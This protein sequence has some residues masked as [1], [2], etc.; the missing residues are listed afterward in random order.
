MNELKTKSGR[1]FYLTIVISVL[2]LFG[3]LVT[4][5]HAE[6]TKNFEEFCETLVT[7]LF[8]Y[9]GGNVGNKWLGGKTEPIKPTKTSRKKTT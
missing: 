4:V 6:L 5:A 2:V 7:V 9:C 3:Y 8:V 1:K